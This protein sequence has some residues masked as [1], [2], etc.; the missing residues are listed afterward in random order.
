MVKTARFH[1]ES[2]GSTLVRE[3]RSHMPH[4]ATKQKRKVPALDVMY[5]IV[6]LVKIAGSLVVLK[7]E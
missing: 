6:L 7:Q 1:A 4:C 2:V 5:V 3:L